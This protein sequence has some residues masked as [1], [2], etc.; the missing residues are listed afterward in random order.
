M[1]MNREQ[2]AIFEASAKVFRT[3]GKNAN[4][5]HGHAGSDVWTDRKQKMGSGDG[6][7]LEL[8]RANGR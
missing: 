8:E 7:L 4:L 3:D 6:V 2:L 5:S 1:L